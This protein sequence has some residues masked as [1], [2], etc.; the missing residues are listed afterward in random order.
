MKIYVIVEENGQIGG[1]GTT[2]SSETDIPIE[3]S[4]T[5]PFLFSHPKYF[6]YID[7]KIVKNHQLVFEEAK[8]RKIAE[9]SEACNAA[10]VGG[11]EFDGNVFQFSERDQANFNQQLTILLLYPEIDS[12][13]WKTE[14]NGVRVFTRE[15][16]IETCKAGERH[17]RTNIG[18][19]WQ[20]QDYIMRHEFESVEEIQKIEFQSPVPEQAAT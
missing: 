9:L 16:F 15:Q 11:F 2:P 20:W 3:V 6:Q 18:H 14:N 4:E 12:V 5:D 19:Y 7:G 17:K 10:I 8:E 1:W 13:T